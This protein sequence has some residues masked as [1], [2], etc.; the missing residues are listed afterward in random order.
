MMF[1][2]LLLAAPAAVT[3]CRML[4]HHGRAPEAAAC[5]QRLSASSDPA[6]RAEALW[7]LRRYD[8][9]GKAFEAALKAQPKNADVRVRYGRLLLQRFNPPDAQKL[10]EE[11]LELQPNNPGALLGESWVATENFDKKSID[12][13]EKALAQDPKLAEAQELLARLHLEDMDPAKSAESAQAALKIFPESTQA[14]AV[15]AA[16]DLLLDKPTVWI[17]K[18]QVV[19][20]RCGSAYL[21][22]AR[23]FVLNRRYDEAIAYYRKAVEFEPDLW[24]ARSE[25]GIQLMRVGQDGPARAEL[26]LAYDAGFKNAATTNSLKLLDSFRNFQK[27]RTDTGVIMLQKKEADLLRPY[28]AREI[29]RATAVYEKKY[30]LKLPRLVEIEVYPDH[31]DFAVRTMGMPGLGALGVTFGLS[32]AMDSPSG[33]KPGSY[34]WASTLWHEMSHVYVLSATNLRVPR[35]FTE[36]VAVHEETAANPEWGDRLTPDMLRA[37]HE[38]K[39]LPVAT[40]DRGFI[41]PTFPAQILISYFQGGRIID[42]IN[43]RYGWP[44]VIAMMNA[45]AAR[46]TTPQV[47]AGVL[48]IK[49]EDFDREFLAWLK[50]QE[51]IPLENFDRW[52]KELPRLIAAYR[53]KRYDEVIAQG[54]VL[55]DLFP[56]FVESGCVYELLATSYLEKGDKPAARAELDAYAKAGGRDPALLK[57]LATLQEEAGSPAQAIAALERINAIAPAGDEELHRRLG[58]LYAQ[59]RNWPAAVV[60]YGSVVYSRPVDAG[61]APAYTNLARALKEAGRPREANDQVLL[62]LEAAPNYRP[63]QKLLLE[64]NNAKEKN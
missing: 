21:S 57:K 11:A 20:P 38:N 52:A 7:G 17:E 32:V 12:M 56:E 55:R 2:L 9:A 44:K 42:Y 25:L 41:R 47:F 28:F 16:N 8:E 33:K 27:T 19:N 64:L 46:Q 23:L 6:L 4:A 22:I 10:F 53:A 31:E 5:W 50:T 39:L 62:A 61:V 58:D 3:D 63:A 14:M 49:D 36:G 45:Y 34:H 30:G 43:G 13:A 29:A 37:I 24:E 59:T 15:L 18:I 26:Q 35:W 1:A 54:R 40:L 48:G 60:E 51:K